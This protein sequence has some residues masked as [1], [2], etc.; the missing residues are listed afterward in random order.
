MR[1]TTIGLELAGLV[2]EDGRLELK[3]ILGVGA[4]GVVYL[5]R[6]W[7]SPCPCPKRAVKC[8]SRT[9]LD[10]RQ[11]TFQRREI[12]LHNIASNHPNVAT[13]YRVFDEGD[14]TFIVMD[15]YPGGDLF[16]MIA[17]R[18]RYIGDDELVRSVFLQIIDAVGHCHDMGIYHRDL[19][20]ENILCSAD[21]TKVVLAD[22]GLATTEAYSRDF[23][24]GS[25][26]Y[27][28]PECQGGL[29]E[30][31]DSYSTIQADLWSLGII[32]VN[33]AC[34]RNPWKQAT[35]E[36][37]TFRAYVDDPSILARI[38]PLSA[39][40]AD[41]CAGLFARNPA[42]RIS[43]RQL[44]Q[45]VINA[46]SF[47]APPPMPVPPPI[48]ARAMPAK[49]A[50]PPPSIASSHASSY[51]SHWSSSCMSEYVQTPSP[52]MSDMYG[53]LIAPPP[54]PYSPHFQHYAAPSTFIAHQPA[55]PAGTPGLVGPEAFGFGRAP[56]SAS[57]SGSLPPTP[58]LS[59]M[60]L[61]QMPSH[62][63]SHTR[64][65]QGVGVESMA[66]FTNHKAAYA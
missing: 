30:P 8:L 29:F 21:G 3:S 38:L 31:V 16:A 49:P 54:S 25:T 20:P 4:Y 14:Y 18:G 62:L 41:I 59:P 58:Q 26:F 63:H 48:P 28:S 12:A 7:S 43:L 40:T 5:A 44:R 66:Y 57:S 45:M 50:R 37:D 56:S 10:E 34:V 33:L 61:P 2:L 19:K 35:L 15:Y 23:G 46:P 9:G 17:D 39:S 65:H 52:D 11:R 51:L 27:L 47:S 6:D 32:L 13:V 36:D 60:P 53:Y 22:F 24:C 1:S 64:K 42:D 55:T